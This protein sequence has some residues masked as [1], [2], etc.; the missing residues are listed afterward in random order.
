M[1]SVRRSSYFRALLCALGILSITLILPQNTSASWWFGGDNENPSKD[2][3]RSLN[4]P[5]LS[6]VLVKVR[7]KY[8]DQARIN[9]AEMFKTALEDLQRVLPPFRAEKKGK[10]WAIFMD[11]EGTDIDRDP[12]NLHE[13]YVYLGR[14]LNFIKDNLEEGKPTLKELEQDV[15]RSVLSTLDPHTV[16]LVPK[17]WAETR[18]NTVGEFG[19]IGVQITIKDNW[20]TVIAP[21]E[22]TPAWRAG[23]KSGD[24]IVEVDGVPT[25]NMAL[26][27]VVEM[28]RG[29]KGKKVVLGIQRKGSLSV[30]RVSIIRDIIHVVSVEH[31]Y[32]PGD[33]GYIRLKHFQEHSDEEVEKAIKN[34][35]KRGR[36]RGL[37]LDLRSDP[38][39]LLEQAIAVADIFLDGGDIVKT[40][41]P[42]N[43]VYEIHRASKGGAETELPMVVLIDSGTA[44]ASEIVAGALKY[45]DR[46]LIIGQRSFGK[47]SVQKIY[48]LPEGNVLKMTVQE[49]LTPGDRSIQ[50][51][52]I[53]P[54]IGTYPAYFSKDLVDIFPQKHAGR[55]EEMER[56]IKRNVKP[57]DPPTVSITY[58]Y[59]A[60][61][62]DE[63]FY[64][65][66]KDE[67]ERVKR[68]LEQ[69]DV[70][71]GIAVLK[72]ASQ[73]SRKNMIKEA[74]PEAEKLGEIE[75]KKIV[76]ELA[77][78]GVDWRAGKNS[79]GKSCKSPLAIV[80][81]ADA[82]FRTGGRAKVTLKVKNTS[83]C[84]V[85]R[86]WAEI[87]APKTV[88][89]QREFL[90]GH[91]PPGKTAEAGVVFDL[92]KS[93]PS[94]TNTL[95]FHFK[96]QAGPVPVDLSRKVKIKDIGR[97]L[98]AFSVQPVDDGSKG[99]K[100]NGDGRPQ[101]G[102]RIALKITVT[103]FG[104]HKSGQNVVTIKNLS[105]KGI[106]I[107]SGRKSFKELRPGSSKDVWLDF[108]VQPFYEKE[109][110]Q[111][112]LSIID[113][114]FRVSL[115]KKLDFRVWRGESFKKKLNGF[116]CT[117]SKE[118]TLLM[119]YAAD[120]AV[121]IGV[122]YKDS[123]FK[124]IE[125]RGK[126]YKVWL[127][128]DA[129][130]FI[131]STDVTFR[132][133]A[134]FKEALFRF[135]PQY[136]P[137]VIDNI[138][139]TATKKNKVMLQFSVKDDRGLKDI[140]G[141]RGNDKIF[142][143]SMG[144]DVRT[145]KIKTTVSLKKGLNRILLIARDREELISRRP[146]VLNGGS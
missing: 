56:A 22:N 136:K 111:I 6:H 23:L 90:I 137:P 138:R 64:T 35:K 51:R 118:K 43:T 13:L 60:K 124:V 52:G 42:N 7:E 103:N 91:I 122:A 78:R 128:G 105:G 140:Y 61:E 9:P 48:Q 33:V 16:L 25:V 5:V 67:A 62:K 28:I 126:F 110:F 89:D 63:T 97:P 45:N 141:F 18:L 88:F 55:E 50:A 21:I 127:A 32:L 112:E 113:S 11:K 30:M 114:D 70:R 26:D 95:K 66:P 102:E 73:A 131:D 144:R 8:Y 41:G 145:K 27:E 109:Y 116:V 76:K 57:D 68:L 53:Q 132:D 37:I 4:L 34:L 29:P 142:Y 14:T 107:H 36:M 49:Y 99:S 58:F 47:G 82:F 134:V 87:D 135:V 130:A 59:K 98:F 79:T 24:K 85:Y 83:L 104:T 106:Y 46:A 133:K 72:K 74:K 101:R 108:D 69:F 31:A 19:G 20:P 40:I 39:G 54:D 123:C 115:T 117:L 10:K 1:T 139:T 3:D 77:L 129:F 96:S 2:Y 93:L 65:P 121:P 94:Q 81:A 80:K 84:S 119:P 38:G 92:P 71:L 86:L 12:K 146:V 120:T 100:G 143:S 17:D 15:T 44:S 75:D 125:K